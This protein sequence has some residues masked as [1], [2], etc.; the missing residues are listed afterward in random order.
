MMWPLF[1]IAYAISC[2]IFGRAYMVTNLRNNILRD[3]AAHRDV[4]MLSAKFQE[5]TGEQ[6]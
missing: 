5:L 1:K 2:R 4:R 3:A 6:L